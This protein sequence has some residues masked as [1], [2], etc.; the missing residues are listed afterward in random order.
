MFT[1]KR[2]AELGY[3]VLEQQTFKIDAKIQNNKKSPSIGYF[4][5]CLVFNV[6]KDQT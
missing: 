3:S 6:P 2:S 1:Q 5:V 4:L